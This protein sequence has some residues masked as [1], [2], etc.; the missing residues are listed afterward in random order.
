[1]IPNKVR[2]VVFRD[3]NNQEIA[4]NPHRTNDYGSFD[5]SFTAP[6]DRLMGMMRIQI[7]GA[8]SPGGSAHVNVEEYKRPKFRV[9]V[10]A[11]AEA[12]KLGGKVK[13]RG[14]ALRA[15]MTI[16]ASQS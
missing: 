4:R 16:F 8:N 2:T 6:R 9:T 12:A 1:M 13:V 5:G 11:P 7:E 10:D 14:S 3:R 15:R